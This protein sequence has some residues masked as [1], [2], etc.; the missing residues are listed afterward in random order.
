MRSSAGDF[1]GGSRVKPVFLGGLP[2]AIYRNRP[3]S[4]RTRKGLVSLF[5][6]G[7]ARRQGGKMVGFTL[8]RFDA[9]LGINTPGPRIMLSKNCAA[10]EAR[11]E[12]IA[13][14]RSPR[15]Q[16][17]ERCSLL[18]IFQVGIVRI[19]CSEEFSHCQRL[20]PHEMQMNELWHW[21]GFAVGKM[22][23]LRATPF[24]GWR[25][26]SHSRSQPIP[27]CKTTARI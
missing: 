12:F 23:P 3:F 4:P 26:F 25:R 15:L 18:G 6:T 21:P 19:G 5:G 22:A 20:I 24:R 16:E 17:I 14:S 11:M 8:I 2:G 7:L 10:I 1:E 27:T 9:V 13:A